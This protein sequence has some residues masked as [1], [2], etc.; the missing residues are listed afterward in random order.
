[1]QK[2]SFLLFLFFLLSS[3]L[4]PADSNF[5]PEEQKRMGI[6]NRVLAKVG[7]S[8]ISVLDVVKKMEVFLN[9]NYPQYADSVPAKYQYFSSQWRDVLMQMIDHQLILL[10]AEKMELKITDGEIRETLFEKFGPNVMASLDKLGISY[11][12]AK[13]MVH[14][15]LA[16]QKMSWFKV[17][18][19]ALSAVNTQDVKSAYLSY[20]KKNPA[21]EEW[22]YQI[23]SVKA[24]SEEVAEQI[25][26]K[27]FELCKQSPSAL[28]SISEKLKD[29]FPPEKDEE[30]FWITVSD[31]LKAEARNISDTYKQILSKLP[32]KSVSQPVKLAGKKD[33]PATYRIFHLQNHVKTP[34]PSLRS[35][36]ERLQSELVQEE[37]EREFRTYISKLRDRYGFDARNLEETIP[38]G[39]QPFSLE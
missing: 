30:S 5:F 21:K 10:D 34:T 19:K 20:C 1:M 12:E 2:R 13:T 31:P 25:A 38:P 9:K 32:L 4:L 24:K 37:S 28:A 23:L 7:D 39:F 18:A 22:E 17:H 14:S 27:A 6:Q 35:L 33:E 11:E 36:Y 8:T 15:E 16:V 3:A 29:S 26:Q